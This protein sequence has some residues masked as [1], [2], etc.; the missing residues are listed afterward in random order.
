MNTK[1]FRDE[2]TKIMP[3]YKW[4]V[5]KPYRL[6]GERETDPGFALMKATGIQSSGFNRM[7][8]LAV[9]RRE[10]GGKVEYEAKIADYGTRGPWVETDKGQTLARALRYV[11]DRCETMERLYKACAFS[12]QSARAQ[13]GE[14][15][16]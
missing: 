5:K 8:T 15:K 11:Q 10:E 6:Y 13:K 1:E 7:S 12:M 4:T 16:A 2:L 9:E 3:G 14:Q